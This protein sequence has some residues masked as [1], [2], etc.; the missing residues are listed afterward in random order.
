MSLH[1]PFSAVGSVMFYQKISPF[2]AI[3]SAPKIRCLSTRSLRL[4]TKK[5]HLLDFLFCQ[6]TSDLFRRDDIAYRRSGLQ[7]PCHACLHSNTVLQHYVSGSPVWGADCSSR[8]MPLPRLLRQK[9]NETNSLGNFCGEIQAL[10]TVVFLR[11]ILDQMPLSSF[12]TGSQ[13]L[14]RCTVHTERVRKGKSCCGVL[15]PSGNK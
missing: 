9:T 3:G 12:Y 15:H 1:R 2:L 7:Y 6:R 5:P 11:P 13:N 4:N 14:K 10:R 8:T